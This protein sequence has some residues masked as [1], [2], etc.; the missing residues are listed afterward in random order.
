[1]DNETSVN[2]TLFPLKRIFIQILKCFLFIENQLDCLQRRELSGGK[3]VWELLMTMM[4]SLCDHVLTLIFL[5][6]E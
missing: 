2:I 1:M 3:H 5:R 4:L 6:Y